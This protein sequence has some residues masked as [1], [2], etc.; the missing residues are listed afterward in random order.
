MR[1]KNY[2]GRCE[3][4]KIDKC[5]GILKSFDA[6]QIAY[7]ELLVKRDDISEIRCNVAI[8]DTEYMTDIVAVKDDGELL[9]REC[10]NRKYLTKPLTVQMLDIS[11][12]FWLQEGVTD[13]G[14]VI[15]AE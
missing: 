1:K 9:V 14:L 15:D 2:K 5:N 3:K 8:G 10:I 7:A 6:L 12:S 4:K 11:R 13:W